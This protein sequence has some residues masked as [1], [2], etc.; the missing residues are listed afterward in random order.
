MR[1]LV[2]AATGCLLSGCAT[3]PA[4]VN[5]DLAT[6]QADVSKAVAGVGIAEG[7]AAAAEIIDPSIKGEVTSIEAIIDPAAKQAQSAAAAAGADAASVEA[8]AQNLAKQ[9]T[10]LEAATAQDV[11]VV[12]NAAAAPPVT[13]S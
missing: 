1:L 6:A 12:A 11:H 13:G 7:I 4:V 8:L 3:L 10:A 9:V 2:L 5:A